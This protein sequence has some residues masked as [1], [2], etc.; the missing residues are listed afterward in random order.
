[1]TGSY[2]R[3]IGTWSPRSSAYRP[4]V[5]QAST[6][7]LPEPTPLTSVPQVPPPLCSD[8]WWPHVHKHHTHCSV[9][10][11]TE[12]G[13]TDPSPSSIRGL[14]RR[15]VEAWTAHVL[16]RT[17]EDRGPP[18][19]WSEDMLQRNPHYSTYNIHPGLFGTRVV[20]RKRLNST[21]PGVPHPLPRPPHRTHAKDSHPKPANDRT[22]TPS[23]PRIWSPL[24]IEQ[25]RRTRPNNLPR[26][27]TTATCAR[28][29]GQD[30]P[31]TGPSPGVNPTIYPS[32]LPRA[33]GKL[34]GNILP[35][36]IKFF[37]F[38][39]IIF[40]SLW[41]REWNPSRT[42]RIE[43]GFQIYSEY[44]QIFLGIYTVSHLWHHHDTDIPLSR[45]VR[46]R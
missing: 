31:F 40:S 5:R 34:S 46:P 39:C 4:F 21:R 33:S 37:F 36:D 2:S 6:S 35:K 44:L 1:M 45:D 16:P 23:R 8:M 30:Y 42:P 7:R 41:N 38:H 20:L 27:N 3:V 29:M 10:S 17:I 11:V 9:E 12:R 14:G 26:R 19:W 18:S 24:A 13:A 28:V 25:Q 15:V 32:S 22:L 43:I